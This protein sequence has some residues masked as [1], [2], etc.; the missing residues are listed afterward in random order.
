MS[1]KFGCCVICN[2]ECFNV[3]ARWP[4]DHR[5]ASQIRQVSGPKLE[6]KRHALLLVNGSQALITTCGECEITPEN[7]PK[8]WR[9]CVAANV[10]EDDPNYRAAIGAQPIPEEQREH[11]NNLLKLMAWNVP[12]GVLYE[13]RWSEI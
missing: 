2:E 12:I 1:R 3:T 6:A 13:Q 5:C 9:Q 4:S 10:R 11:R 7:L 8:I